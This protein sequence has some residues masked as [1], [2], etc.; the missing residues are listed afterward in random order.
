VAE[1]ADQVEAETAPD[2]HRPIAVVARAVP[3]GGP[4]ADLVWH[5]ARAQLE[6]DVLLIGND[7]FW[8]GLPAGPITLQRLYDAVLVQREP[9]G[10]SGFSSLYVATLTGADLA[11]IRDHLSRGLYSLY[12]RDTSDRMFD[13]ARSLRV[14]IDKRALVHAEL[15]YAGAPRLREGSARPAG[16]LVDVL[17][18][19][20]RARTAAGLPLDGPLTPTK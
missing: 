14:A 3:Q 13:R 1:L 5:A 4:M 20:A 16:E 7:L 10:T 8:D 11:W 9:S 6:A 19:F 18:A 2:A 17:E 12:M 15:A